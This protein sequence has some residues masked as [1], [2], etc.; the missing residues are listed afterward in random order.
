MLVYSKPATLEADNIKVFFNGAT[1]DCSAMI[2]DGLYYYGAKFEHEETDFSEYPFAIVSGDGT[3]IYLDTLSEGLN[4]FRISLNS[5]IPA[6][7]E[8]VGGGASPTEDGNAIVLVTDNGHIDMTAPDIADAIENGKNVFINYDGLLLYFECM[9]DGDAI[10]TF[11]GISSGTYY[12]VDSN[13]D[14]DYYDGGDH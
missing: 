5:V 11:P 7:W 3:Q 8:K 4:D 2:E 12:Y 9:S 6:V 1:Y 14:I 10:F 13:G